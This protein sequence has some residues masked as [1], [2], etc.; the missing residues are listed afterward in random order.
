MAGGKANVFRGTDLGMLGSPGRLVQPG[1]DI[2][3]PRRRRK[4]KCKQ[5]DAAAASSRNSFAHS[6]GLHI[7]KQCLE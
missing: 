6:S 7:P 4:C 3:L 2:R 5:R 1:P